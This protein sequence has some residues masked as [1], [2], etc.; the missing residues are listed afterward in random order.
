MTI[1]A[2]AAVSQAAGS[3][4]DANTGGVFIRSAISTVSVV[5]VDSA[6]ANQLNPAITTYNAANPAAAIQVQA[7]G[8]VTVAGI[9]A[10]GAGANVEIWARV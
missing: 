6:G 1:L 10:T 3:S 8:A 9:D 5:A 7:S 2:S 4:I